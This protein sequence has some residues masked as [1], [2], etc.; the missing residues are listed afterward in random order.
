MGLRPRSRASRAGGAPLKVATQA[1]VCSYSSYSLHVY[2]M[3]IN[4][5]I[6]SLWNYLKATRSFVR[7][8]RELSQKSKIAPLLESILGPFHVH[9]NS[10]N[11]G[12]DVNGTHVFRDFHLKVPE[13]KWNFE[14]VVLFLCWKLGQSM[15]HLR[16]FTMNHRFQAIYGDIC[17]TI[18]NFGNRSINQ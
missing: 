14:K 2:V 16:V 9:R 3:K 17:A 11:S 15:F 8:Q 7:K 6:S 18:L 13:K 10:G 1:S 4:Q 5:Y 12:W